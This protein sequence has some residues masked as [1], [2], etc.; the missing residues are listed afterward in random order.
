MSPF[1]Q[2]GGNVHP[3]QTRLQRAWGNA[4]LLMVL[5]T[6]I[7]GGNAVASRFA[8]GNISPMALTSFRWIGVCL[9][10]PFLLRRQIAKNA[11]IQTAS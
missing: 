11:A 1:S 5:T 7:W 2:Q 4:Y 10:M 6:L 8:V 3:T 9:I